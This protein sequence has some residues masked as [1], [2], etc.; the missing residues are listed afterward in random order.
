MLHR[1]GDQISFRESLEFK[2]V[3]QD[4][5]EVLTV[6]QFSDDPNR[7]RLASVYQYE[8]DAWHEQVR[9]IKRN[10]DI[11]DQLHTYWAEVEASNL[12]KE[13]ALGN[14]LFDSSN[15]QERNNIKFP[16]LS[17][18]VTVE[19]LADKSL[20]LAVRLNPEEKT[21]VHN[22]IFVAFDNENL[23]SQAFDSL[24]TVINGSNCNIVNTDDFEKIFSTRSVLLSTKCRWRS[25]VKE[26][27]KEE[28][29]SFEIYPLPCFFVQTKPTGL[30]EAVGSIIDK[31]QETGEIPSH[32]VEIASPHA[33]PTIAPESD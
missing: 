18:P 11:F 4:G 16:I 26:K 12:K 2:E 32:L 17:S 5:N 13:M 6:E 33:Y 23:N 21:V 20:K 25:S 24:K 15:Y 9:I 30:K 7:V 14:F 10:N 27:R 19:I 1:N 29:V 3:D 22:E 31:I 8:L 28:G